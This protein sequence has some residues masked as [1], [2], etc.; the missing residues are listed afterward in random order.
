MPYMGSPDSFPVIEILL[1][2]I[3]FETFFFF[4]L[5][6]YTP[7]LTGAVPTQAV[8]VTSEYSQVGRWMCCC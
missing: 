2:N 8:G 6:S 7:I 5:K 4:F 1:F 3:T